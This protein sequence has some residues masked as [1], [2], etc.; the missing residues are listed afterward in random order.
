M[1]IFWNQPMPVTA[2]MTPSD[3]DHIYQTK[4][5]KSWQQSREQDVALQVSALERLDN[6]AKHIAGLG[7]VLSRR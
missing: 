2:L 7:K 6:V 3:I 4:A 1:A 5:F